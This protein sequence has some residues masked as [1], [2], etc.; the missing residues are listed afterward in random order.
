MKR[1]K[2]IRHKAVFI[3]ACFAVC[4]IMT[5][6]GHAAG[7]KYYTF[8]AGGSAGSWYVGSAVMSELIRKT[9]PTIDIT[10]APGGGV[11]NM[12]TLQAGKAEIGFD[13]SQTLYE[14]YT[15]TGDFTKRADKLRAIMSTIP[16]YLQMAVSKNGPIQ[17]ATDLVGKRISPSKKGFGAELEFRRLLPFYSL[18]YEKI[19]QAGG[20]VLYRNYNDGAMM[21]LDGHLDEITAGSP[22]P[23]P[24]FTRIATTHPIRLLPVDPK[25][26]AAYHKK[27]PGFESAMIPAGTYAGQ[28]K[29]VPTLAGYFGIVTTTAV[30]DADVYCMTKAI[31]EGRKRIAESYGAYKA[32][33]EPGAVLKGIS[34][35]MHPAAKKYFHEIGLLK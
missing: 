23:H 20:Q 17:S 33:L 30:P 16:F 29:P 35:P 15:G 9:C 21:F 24:P 13:I 2:Q 34:I 3:L 26:A 8:A 27:Y 28:T 7:R 10:P 31:Y 32:M 25:I 19:E 11:A 6:S 1:T 5:S 14:A 4:I 12:R 22:A 18:S